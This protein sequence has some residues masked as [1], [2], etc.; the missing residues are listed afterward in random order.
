MH[1]I[2]KKTFYTL[3]AFCLYFPNV[4]AKRESRPDLAASLIPDSLKNDFSHAVLR[5]DSSYL[6]VVNKNEIIFTNRYAVTVLNEKGNDYGNLYLPY[7]GLKDIPSITGTYYDAQGKPVQQIRNKDVTDQSTFGKDYAFNSDNRV[8]FFQYVSVT[9]PYTVVFEIKSKIKS[10]LFLPDWHPQTASDLSVE[11]STFVLDYPDSIPIRSKT[12]NMPASILKTSL[13]KDGR[14]IQSWRMSAIPAFEYQPFSSVGNFNSPALVLGATNFDLMG[15]SGQSDSWKAFGLFY[16]ELNKG[17]DSLSPE[18]TLKVKTLTNK[19]TSVLEKIQ[20][21]Y[22]YMQQNTRY[23]LD[24]SGIAAWQTFPATEVCS[25]GYGDC[26]GLT[27]YL[28]A[29]LKAAGVP[30]FTALVSAGIDDYYKVDPSFPNNYFNHVILCIPNHHDSIWVECTSSVFPAGYLSDFTDNRYALICGSDGGKLV[31]TPDYGIHKNFIQHKATFRLQPSDQNQ[32]VTLCNYYS[33]PMQDD[34]FELLKQSPQDA[35]QKAENTKFNFP[36]YKIK[37]IHY[38]FKGT[39][40][41]PAIQENAEVSVTGI[42]NK[43]G[44]R[45]FIRMDWLANPMNKIIQISP[46][47]KPLVFE[48][49]YTV[50]DSVILEIPEGFKV[51]FMPQ[52]ATINYPFASFQYSYVPLANKIIYYRKYQYHK[53]IYPAS[54]F[55]DYVSLYRKLNQ[56][57]NTSDIVLI[58]Q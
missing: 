55:K 8:K 50:S 28:K 54:Y 16:Y 45:Y 53:G 3:L 37:N 23:V 47:T 46:R 10:T 58:P 38:D 13:S 40:L 24:A 56:Q 20:T 7:S 4:Q 15:H 29:L 27:N 57:R 9:Y 2:I 30:S 21:L 22:H 49:S 18:M 31:K 11:K 19:D 34:L 14:N 51:E 42:V 48:H 25:K 39:N 35:I 52:N 33:G 32:D 12:Y 17:R 6:Q 41:L 1:T 26:K 44:S 5:F 36:S 43:T